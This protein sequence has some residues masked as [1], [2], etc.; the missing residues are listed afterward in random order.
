VP[1]LDYEYV[2]EILMKKGVRGLCLIVLL[3]VAG[4]AQIET[5]TRV[6]ESPQEHVLL[7]PG[8]RDLY[9]EAAIGADRIKAL[10]GY[11]DLYLKTPKRNA[12]AY[13]TVQLQ[14]SRDA[15]LI[16]TAGILGWPVADMLIRPD[17]LFVHDMLNNKMLVGRNNGENLGKL[18]GVQAGFGQLTE[19]LFGM[20]GMPE[21][22]SAIESV[23]QGGGKVG[24]MVRSGSGKKE[25][26]VD[27]ASKELEEITLFDSTGRRTVEFRFI[28]YQMQPAG[29]GQERMPK[30]IDMTL[31]RENEIEGSRSL[32]VVY[33][34]RI[35]INPPAF[36]ITFRRPSKARTV[37][38]DEVD[39]MPW[40]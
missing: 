13:C 23:R 6:K 34:E 3:A 7:T 22:A 31:F 33:D 37:N 11:A 17:S 30:E 12:K 20:A 26:L 21:P 39:H 19:T 25:I 4:C 2:K 16:V 36:T 18:I 15:R 40:L 27:S 9:R 14:K 10:D 32:R 29:E 1:G 28:G 24:F 8:L 5:V 38:L 35:V